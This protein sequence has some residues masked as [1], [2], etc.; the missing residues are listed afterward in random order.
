LLALFPLVRAIVR[1]VVRF[2][3]GEVTPAATAAFESELQRL[4]REVGRV[5]VEWT[6]NHLEP[7]EPVHMHAQFYWQGEYYRRRRKSR[8]RKLAC[9]FGPIRLARYCYQP[10]E[11]CGRCLHPLDLQLGIVADVATPAL[12]ELVGRLSADLT[13]R[14]LL[15]QL[16]PLGIR[17]GVSTLRKLQQT[18]AEALEGFRHPSQVEQVLA[19]LRAAAGSRGTRRFTLA[20]GRDGIMLPIVRSGK[21]KEAAAATLSVL[22]RAGHRLGTV[23]LGQMPEAGQ[24]TL[25]N[26]L[27]RLVTDVLRQWEGDLPRLIYVTDA[28]QHPTAYFEQVLSP[29]RH[30]LTDRPLEWEWIVDYY[31]ACQYVTQLAESIFGPTR[32]AYAWAAKWRRWLKNKPDGVFRVLRSAGAL[33]SRRGLIGGDA[34][35]E[36][37]STA[38]HYLRS[39]ASKMD[40]VHYRRLKLPIGSGVTEAAC[41]TLF[42]QRFKQ[43]GM[44][45]T[46]EGG[47][48]ILTFRTLVLSG[49]WTATFDRYL[50]SYTSPQPVTPKRSEPLNGDFSLKTAV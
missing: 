4:L 49:T 31:H 44:K 41:K 7:E 17:W 28:G 34:A 42:T 16:R 47:A 13:Q 11:I 25:S 12:A 21:Y 29:M 33:R 10:L 14:Q 1:L 48:P 30:P 24:V 8:C 46:V 27:T 32:E 45:W 23:Y 37:Y 15:A 3:R 36:K 40:Y 19:W 26:Q 18:L 2:R 22:D 9:L 5:I 6:Y 38:Y 50:N 20:L 43:S 39:R 35:E